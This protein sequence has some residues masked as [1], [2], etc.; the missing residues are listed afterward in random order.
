MRRVDMNDTALAISRI[1]RL[2][3]RVKPEKIQEVE[4][5]VES[6]TERGAEKPSGKKVRKMEGIWEGL[7]F[8]NIDEEKEIREIRKESEES[9]LKRSAKWNT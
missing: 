2:L 5:F 7:G 8:E 6:L 3:D 9:L 4:D 1:K